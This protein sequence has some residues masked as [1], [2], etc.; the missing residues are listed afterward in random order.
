[1]YNY[2]KRFIIVILLLCF[3]QITFC[4]LIPYCQKG[5]WGFATKEGKIT[6]PCVYEAVDF[7]TVDNLAKVKKAGKYGYIDLKATTVIPFEYDDCVR[8]YEVFN[9]EN[10]MGIKKN[11]AIHLDYMFDYDDTKNNRYIVTKNNTKGVISILDGKPKMIIPISFSLIQFDPD[12]KIFLCHNNST[13]VY[14]D[15]A[16]NNLTEEK[17]TNIKRNEWASVMEANFE[18]NKR[19]IVKSANGKVGVVKKSNNYGN[20]IDTIIQAKYDEMII[21]ELHLYTDVF[22][23][24]NNNKWGAIDDKS[25]LLLPTQYDSIN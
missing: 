12:K 18:D 23:I 2:K 11:K 16:G 7:Y 21:D 17:V 3:Y 9:G 24:K 25:N 4:Q 8:I 15:M 6:I 22:A 14:F 1:M 20:S 13:T 10:S 19:T 5:K